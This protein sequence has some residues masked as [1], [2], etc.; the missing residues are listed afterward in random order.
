MEVEA[1]SDDEEKGEAN[2]EKGNK[3]VLSVTGYVFDGFDNTRDGLFQPKYCFIFV[4]FD[5]FD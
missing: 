2:E 5:G 1:E 3:V 4:G